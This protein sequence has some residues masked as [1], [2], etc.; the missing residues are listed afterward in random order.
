MTGA[1]LKWIGTMLVVAILVFFGREYSRFMMRRLSECESFLFLLK[2]IKGEIGRCLSTPRA[3]FKDYKDDNL[4]RVG[5]LNLQRSGK[6][7]GE[8]FDGCADKLSLPVQ[9]KDRLSEF[10]SHFGENYKDGEISQ[11]E[12]YVGEIEPLLNEER[13]RL[14][15]RIKLV[16]TLVAAVSLGLII[17][18]V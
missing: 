11:I 3:I 16:K 14:P 10:F 5:F 1:L 13:T 18:I 15:E 12:Y 4:E 7:L 17:L 9:I 8:C 6:S 2:R